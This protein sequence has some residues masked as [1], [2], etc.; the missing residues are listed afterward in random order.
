MNLQIKSFYSIHIISIHPSYF[1]FVLFL[2][3]IFFIFFFIFLYFYFFI[4]YFYF[5]CR[6]LKWDK[7]TR[8]ISNRGTD[9]KDG[10][11]DDAGH[12]LRCRRAPDKPPIQ[13][14]TTDTRCGTLPT[15]DWTPPKSIRG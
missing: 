1:C 11:Q 14:S 5:F 13:K 3:F 10:S 6:Y 7:T 4:F 12:F 8:D 2:F 9:D 15:K